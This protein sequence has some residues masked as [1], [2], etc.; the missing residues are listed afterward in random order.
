MKG[1]TVFVKFSNF[2]IARTNDVEIIQNN[3]G[4]YHL[5]SL[6]CLYWG[7]TIF[8]TFWKILNLECGI[9][10]LFWKKNNAYLIFCWTAT[11]LLAKFAAF[12]PF[13]PKITISAAKIRQ[14]LV[15]KCGDRKVLNR[16]F[17]ANFATCGNS[18]G[19]LLFCWTADDCTSHA[20]WFNY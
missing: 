9:N 8:F 10:S 2:D 14:F 13:L 17:M 19:H 12:S 20:W 15:Q 11:D 18:G 7:R 16:P 4:Q 3:E 1:R 6:K 5:E